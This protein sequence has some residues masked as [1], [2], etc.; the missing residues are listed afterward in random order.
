MAISGVRDCLEPLSNAIASKLVENKLV[1]THSKNSLEEQLRKCLEKLTRSDDFEVDYQI[2]PIRNLVPD[3][4][5]VS[6]YVTAFVIEKLI[7][8]KDTVDVFGS[9][10]EI[11]FNINRQVKKFL[12]G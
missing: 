3:P 4:H 5:I 2:A 7:E 11:Y 10:E 6:I 12:P 1:E 9:D 8:H